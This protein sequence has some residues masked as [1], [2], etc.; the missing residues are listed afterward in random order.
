[1]G[2]SAD[3]L[4]RLLNDNVC[5][6]VFSKRTDGNE[7]RMLCTNSKLLLHSIAGR[8]ALHFKDPK[9]VGLPYFPKDK[10]LVVTWDIIWQEFRQI[11]LETVN[12][13]SAIPLKS[14]EDIKNFWIFFDKKLQDKTAFEKVAWNDNRIKL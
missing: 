10:G 4:V 12:V 6:V 14:E 5:E 1:M 2:F 9:G 11:P 3:S 8:G 7:R 13:I